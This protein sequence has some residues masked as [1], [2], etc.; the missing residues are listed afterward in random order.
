M[1]ELAKVK[2]VIGR[3]CPGAPHETLLVLDAT[4]GQNGIAQARLFHEALGLTGLV[5]T[6][7]DGTA[8]GGIVVRIYREL[9]VPD[10]AGGHRRAARGPGA[11]RSRRVRRRAGRSLTCAGGRPFR[12]PSATPSGW[13]GRSVMA[14]RRRRADVAESGG[15]R[16]AGAGRARGR[17]GRAPA[18]RRAPRRGGG[19]GGGGPAARGA[20]PATSPSSPAPT[21]GARRRAPTR[22]S[23]A[24]RGARGGRPGGDP[25][26]AGGRA[27]ARAP[28]GGRGRP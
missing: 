28:P 5:L 23:R 17:R 4:T 12:G 19:A 7:L 1:A 16:R 18:G 21:S 27:R 25:N 2:R 26:P 9:G 20:R 8:K 3:Q 6:K 13:S 14:A 10:Q 22:S 24:G 15:R 11:V